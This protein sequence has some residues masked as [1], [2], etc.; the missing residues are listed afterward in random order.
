MADTHLLPDLWL[1]QPRPLLDV[2]YDRTWPAIAITTCLLLVLFH[3]QA[4]GWLTRRLRV[5]V[6]VQALIIGG[7][8]AVILAS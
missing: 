8:L 1:A 6:K 3:A 2:G 5:S 7:L 4:T